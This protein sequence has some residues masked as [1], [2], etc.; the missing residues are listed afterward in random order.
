[1]ISFE[2]QGNFGKTE[3]F[4]KKLLNADMYR[5]LDSLAKEG[6]AALSSATPRE[7]GTTAA[8][9]SY[10]IEIKRDSAKITWTNSHRPNGFPVA[11]MLQHGHGTRTGGY[12][13]GRDYI[14][15]AIKPVMDKI[16]DGV[17]KAVKS[18]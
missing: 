13:Q 2:S 4:L 3:S 14:N 11:V 7:F 18:A 15:P 9:W 5:S 8:S 17:W 12:V 1:M 16:S 10:T 6:V